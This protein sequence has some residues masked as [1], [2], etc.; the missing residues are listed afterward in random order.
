MH[1]QQVYYF[2][3][4]PVAFTTLLKSVGHMYCTEYLLHT[5]KSGMLEVS[6]YILC[7]EKF[8]SK[9]HYSTCII[10]YGTVQHEPTDAVIL[11]DEEL[12]GKFLCT[13]NYH[14]D[15]E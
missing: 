12:S 11:L 15:M 7:I 6:T 4:E 14:I 13:S 8:A 1:L 9:L 2:L 3:L 10:K 5:E